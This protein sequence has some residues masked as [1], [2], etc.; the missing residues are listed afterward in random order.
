MSFGNSVDTKNV[1]AL[2]RKTTDLGLLPA[3]VRVLLLNVDG[4]VWNLLSVVSMVGSAWLRMAA[5]IVVQDV[6]P[7]W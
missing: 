7:G 5:R 6:Y 1:H 2:M 4:D 3:V